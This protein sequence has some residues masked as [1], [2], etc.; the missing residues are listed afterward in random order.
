MCA[1]S[2]WRASSR[3]L[4]G[5]SQGGDHVRRPP[6]PRAPRRIFACA[7]RSAARRVRG[8]RSTFSVP[9]NAG[10]ELGRAARRR[11]AGGGESAG[12]SLRPAVLHGQLAPRPRPLCPPP[13]HLRPAG[14]AVLAQRRGGA[15]ALC[16][17]V[18]G[19]REM[20]RAAVRV[21]AWTVSPACRVRACA[22][23]RPFGGA[24]AELAALISCA[25]ALPAISP[26]PLT[27]PLSA[28]PA[29]RSLTVQLSKFMRCARPSAAPGARGG[30]PPRSL[31]P[32]S[33][34]P[35][36]WPKCSASSSSPCCYPPPS[37][38]WPGTT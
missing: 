34:A 27:R 22:R 36:G 26:S 5:T 12:L 31:R 33:P 35:P 8:H 17:R 13:R 21:A 20:A 11:G 4:A 18:S 6:Q 25:N 19:E 16:R 38:E 7:R 28:S 32:A 2:L 23:G 10:P 30:T 24:E 15:N 3:L 29:L 1:L 14:G 37:P 9:A